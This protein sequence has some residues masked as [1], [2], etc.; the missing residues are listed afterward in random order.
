MTELMENPWY[1][2]FAGIVIEVVL[3][4]LLFRTGRGVLLWAM[5][6][7]LGLTL[8]GVLVERLVVTERER[9][10]MTLDGITAA[11]EAN[12]LHRLFTF[13]APEA[14]QTRQRATWALGQVEVQSARIYKV[15]I[16]INKL[17]SP[18]TAKALF[19]GHIACRDKKGE[20]PYNNYASN[21][22]VDLRKDGDKWIVTGHVEEQDSEGKSR[23]INTE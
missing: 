4:I 6:A 19:F 2:I 20:F 16:S 12:D 8:L 22:V 5:I 17:T 7:V 10:Q 11:L 18:P 23:V 1:F 3:G 14:K 13:V 21:F 9:V 15:Q